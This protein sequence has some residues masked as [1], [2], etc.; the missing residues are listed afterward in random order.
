MNRADQQDVQ[1]FKSSYSNGTSDCVEVA[2]LDG[3][4]A[5][6][7]TKDHGAGTVTVGAAGWRSFVAATDELFTHRP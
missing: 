4:V 6:R 7:D 5:M 1:W 3:A 2:D